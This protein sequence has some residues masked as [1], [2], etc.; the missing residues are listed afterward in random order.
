MPENPS[1]SLLLR[2]R[3]FRLFY[4][5]DVADQFGTSV[6]SVGVPLLAIS[7]LH[8][9][10]FAVSLLS[11]FAWLPWLLIALPV[12]VWVDRTRHR[13]VMLASALASLTL[14]ASVP[15]VGGGIGYLL[16]VTLLLG[17]ASVFYQTAYR[18]YLPSLVAPE[19]LAEGNAK[20]HGSASA[21]QIVGA[22]GGGLLTQVLGGLHVLFVNASTFVVSVLCL[23]SIRTK[24]ARPEPAERVMRREIAEGLRLVGRDP[25]IR[26]LTLF[27]AASNLALMAYQSILPVFLIRHVGLGKGAVGLLVAAAGTGGVLGAFL[28]RRVAARIGTARATLLFEIGFALPALFIPLTTL[29]VGVLCYPV[30]AFCVG[31]G[32][33]AGNVLK[34]GFLQGYCPP[35]L[36]GRLSA[37]ASFVNYGTLPLGALL[38]GTLGTL[39]GI[40]AAIW[41]TTAG[42]PLAGVVLLLSPLR[43][44]RDLPDTPLSAETPTEPHLFPAGA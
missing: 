37:S 4:V 18:A 13:P 31:A 2:H 22:G 21:A 16:A 28:A 39:L 36:L 3:D 5:G 24:E 25:W 27:G 35:R 43:R 9:G 10:T 11:M 1:R 33:V 40:P 30:G 19:D 8:A 12:G 29:G 32:V 38:G 15:L 34:S 44:V 23:V 26:S 6:T 42:V 7:T 41:I 20:L 14:L 17:A